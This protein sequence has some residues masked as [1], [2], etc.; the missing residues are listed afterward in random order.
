MNTLFTTPA[1][2]R[3]SPH[4]P[5]TPEKPARGTCTRNFIH[6]RHDSHRPPCGQL[7]S[8]RAHSESVI[9]GQVLSGQPCVHEK[10][11]RSGFVKAPG[12]SRPIQAVASAFEPAATDFLLLVAVFRRFKY[13][14]RRLRFSALLYCLLI[15][16]LYFSGQNRLFCQYEDFLASI[17]H[18]FGRA[19]GVGLV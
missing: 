18:L 11:R 19:R 3:P 1:P 5:F 15:Y 8:T 4:L 6:R 9:R 13:A 16:G 12:K 7:L 14:C 2:L 17:Q 10:T